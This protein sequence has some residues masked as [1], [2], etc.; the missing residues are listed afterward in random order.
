[1]GFLTGGYDRLIG[2]LHEDLLDHGVEVRT[3]TPVTAVTTLP[4]DR[5]RV[6]I[7]PESIEVD[8]VISTL[9]P[10]VLR[11]LIPT[12]VPLTSDDR[13][14]VDYLAVVV[15][16]LV[17]PRSLTPFY[18][19]NLGENLPFTGVIEMTNLA[20]PGT[21]GDE[22]VVYL[23]RYLS[24]D[25]PWRSASD[26]EVT[27]RFETALAGMFPG[28]RPE[29]VTA[30]SVERAP[31]VQPLHTRDY[32]DKKPPLILAPGLYNAS[33]SQV[34][35]WPVNNDQIRRLAVSVAARVRERAPRPGVIAA[36]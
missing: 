20:P 5:W 9:P 3:G 21:F 36:G 1:M 24:P 33:S 12:A 4:D 22:A 11:R 19:L 14:P 2:A 32:L 29:T 30:R 10:P 7:G 34:F 6:E 18:I 16:I 25:D 35:P 17:L 31:F 15:E 13:A 27:T 23:P 26:D 8:E 28:F